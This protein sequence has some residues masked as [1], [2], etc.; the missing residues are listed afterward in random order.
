M[1]LVFEVIENNLR[2]PNG[3][4]MRAFLHIDN[5][6][7]WF[8]YY[9][10][11]YLTIYDSEGNYHDIGRI[12]IGEKG[13]MAG[14]PAIPNEFTKLAENFF[15]LGQDA[16]F[17]ENLYKLNNDLLIQIVSGLNDIVYNRNSFVAVLNE[18]V[19][20]VSLLRSVSPASIRGQFYRLLQGGA[21]LSKYKFKFTLPSG[22]N[23]AGLTVEF[24]VEPESDPPT[25]IHVLI[26]RNGVGKTHLL[27]NMVLYL[28]EDKINHLDSGFSSQNDE[29]IDD[30]FSG[31][32]SVSFSA[33]DPFN[34]LRVQKI[35]A[36]GIRYSYVGLKYIEK[37]G[38]D[39]NLMDHSKLAEEFAES[40][41]F[42]LKSGGKGMQWENALISLETDPL[43]SDAGLRD[44]IKIESD[45]E[46][47]S[48]ASAKFIKL[49]SGHGIG[50][51]T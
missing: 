34:P 42:C 28:V 8:I 48:A 31:V 17:Y 13:M 9:T 37:N 35:Q 51:P 22:K 33:F 19:T 32:V 27:N 39:Y 38:H 43:F 49:S 4:K 23:V 36:I 7:D 50:L 5:W 47:K 21:R 12:K 40:L 15:S 26:G 10:L 2:V 16:D 46:L 45:S 6:N 24:S 44:L 3:H 18:N 30:I 41:H 20:Q 1:E 25:N 29:S 11:Y 14:R